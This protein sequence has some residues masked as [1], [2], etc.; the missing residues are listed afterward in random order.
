MSDT[1]TR[2]I[3]SLSKRERKP[4]AIPPAN[5]AAP[6]P[7]D[8]TSN[9]AIP[10]AA[11]TPQHESAARTEK[12][13]QINA[14]L[15]AEVRTRA[16]AAYRAVGFTSGYESFSDLVAKALEREVQRLELEHNNGS[17]VPGGETALSSGRPMTT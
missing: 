14:T 7:P 16:R 9:K 12:K 5:D 4:G 2:K 11:P 8:T 15:P 10:A 1:P 17:P 13:V 3:G 6:T